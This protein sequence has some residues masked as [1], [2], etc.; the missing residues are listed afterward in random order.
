VG[1]AATASTQAECSMVGLN[2][3]YPKI[4]NFQG[5][6]S[7]I[8]VNMESAETLRRRGGM[9]VHSQFMGCVSIESVNLRWVEVCR[10]RPQVT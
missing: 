10:H 7:N 1:G 6:T 9:C 2:L 8:A 5:D 3:H 4:V